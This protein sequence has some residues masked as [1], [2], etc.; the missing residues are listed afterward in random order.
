MQAA[1]LTNRKDMAA[2]KKAH[3]CPHL[4]LPFMRESATVEVKG[5]KCRV[6][7][8]ERL[9]CSLQSVISELGDDYA[10]VGCRW[11]QSVCWN[12]GREGGTKPTPL[13]LSTRHV[14]AAV[15]I[16]VSAA[17]Q[18]AVDVLWALEYLH[19]HGWAHLDVKS[20]NICLSTLL[21]LQ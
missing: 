9:D 16:P 13:F 12:A 17:C 20:G 14:P 1:K 21:P 6:L 18:L 11:A 5:E 19:D 15:Q 8:L 10:C 2:W 7:F 4:G 3:R